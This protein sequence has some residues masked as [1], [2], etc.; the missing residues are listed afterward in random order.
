M[1]KQEPVKENKI[2]KILLD[3]GVQTDHLNPT[4]RPNR[5]LIN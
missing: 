4:G 5:V 3:F 2:P 1:H